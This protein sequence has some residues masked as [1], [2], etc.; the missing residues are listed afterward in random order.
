MWGDMALSVSRG[1]RL[2]KPPSAQ[3]CGAFSLLANNTGEVPGFRDL[4]GPSSLRDNR[5]GLRGRAGMVWYEHRTETRGQPM[6]DN[7]AGAAAKAART[8]EIIRA[9]IQA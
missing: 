1:L 7:R 2:G 5:E 4:Q 6:S 8:E 3:S 9:Y